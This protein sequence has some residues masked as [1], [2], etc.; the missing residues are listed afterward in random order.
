MYSST[1]LGGKGEVRM[2][3]LRSREEGRKVAVRPGKPGGT[4][5]E[6]RVKRERVQHIV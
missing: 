2:R 1:S 6:G 3:K 5:K 4:R